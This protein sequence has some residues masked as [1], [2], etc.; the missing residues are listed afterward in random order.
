MYNIDIHISITENIL[1]KPVSYGSMNLEQLMIRLFFPHMALKRYKGQQWGQ[2]EQYLAF[3]NGLCDTLTVIVFTVCAIYGKTTTCFEF[4][5]NRY[6]IYSFIYH[7]LSTVSILQLF[8]I[9]Y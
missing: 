6:M 7:P 3:V 9:S 1:L 5:L 2:R 4:D 8:T